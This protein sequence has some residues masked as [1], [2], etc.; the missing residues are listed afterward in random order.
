MILGLV[1]PRCAHIYSRDFSF[2]VDE[3][4]APMPNAPKIKPSFFFDKYLLPLLACPK[5]STLALQIFYNGGKVC[6][7][8]CNHNGLDSDEE[9]D[10]D[11]GSSVDCLLLPSCKARQF[12][13]HCTIYGGRMRAPYLSDIARFATGDLGF[14]TLTLLEITIQGLDDTDTTH[15]QS[16][17]AILDAMG[18]LH[19]DAREL[20]V[21]YRPG[22]LY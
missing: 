10:A 13:W 17:H 9:S 14:S 5:I 15:R 2:N 8:A 11:D 7:E 18:T 16:I 3:R 19:Y 20:R 12:V 1:I 22:E 6:I 21:E 4:S